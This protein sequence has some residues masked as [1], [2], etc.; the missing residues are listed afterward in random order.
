MISSTL[1]PNNVN[2]VINTLNGI[3]KLENVNAFLLIQAILMQV[4]LFQDQ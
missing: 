2:H 3:K 1:P 4:D